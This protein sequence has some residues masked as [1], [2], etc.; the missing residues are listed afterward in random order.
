MQASAEWLLKFSV[1]NLHFNTY[2]DMFLYTLYS[3]LENLA[4]FGIHT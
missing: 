1:Q 3:Q 4:Y 2:Y